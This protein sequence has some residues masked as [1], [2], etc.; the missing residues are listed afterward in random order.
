MT[1]KLL[2][3]A[4]PA[5]AMAVLAVAPSANA[6]D[7][8]V[9]GVPEESI[10]QDWNDPVRAS[11]AQR[12]ITYGVNWSGEYWN[13]VKGGNSTG[14]NFDG[15][16][17]T[18][19]DID[20]EKLLGWKGGA[21]HASA[22]YL[23]GMG[24]STERVGNIFAVSNIEGLET[25]RLFE[26]WYEQSLLDDKLKVRI[27]S[28]AAD[29]EF[30]ISENAALFLNGTFGWAAATAA[31]MAAGG[32]G[33]PL[34]S[35]GVRVQYAPTDNLTI[36]AAVFNG[37]PADPFAEDP[38]ADN[39]HGVE[40]RLEDA[41]LMMIEGQFKY[42][43]AGLPGT[44]KLGGWK[45]F[46]HYAPEFLN[47]AQLE[48]DHGLYGII[49]QQ[50]WKGSDDK[51]VSVFA[52]VAGSPEAQSLIDA[53]VDTGIVFT[54][55]VPGRTNDSFG[56]AFGYGNISGDLARAQSDPGSEFASNVIS[57]YESVLELN[58]IAQIRP[59]FSI[60]P[61]FQYIWNPGGRIGSDADN[62]KP[63]QDAAVFGVRTNISY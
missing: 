54:G 3:G 52:R 9:T 28:L 4:L 25:F 22:Y 26:L 35:L 11:F 51:V 62:T 20:L 13:V 56:A 18:Y 19:T 27:G 36:L 16:L 63:I 47:P 45:Q 55:F 29:S 60:V 34:A 23:H 61:D 32:P 24:P 5:F 50:I 40:F 39:R 58:Y 37:S 49:D 15:L 6:E 43:L 14:S 57:D 46:N 48:T 41:P 7:K 30:F 17:A 44:V 12:G 59:G 31:N 33:Y 42:N 53:Y 2:S 8:P 1:S 10:A 21:I 38:Q